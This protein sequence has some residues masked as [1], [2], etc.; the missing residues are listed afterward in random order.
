MKSRERSRNKSN[1]NRAK[2]NKSK[3]RKLKSDK[4]KDK[5]LKDNRTKEDKKAKDNRTKDS[6]SRDNKNKDNRDKSKKSKESKSS[7]K[8]NKKISDQIKSLLM[9]IKKNKKNNSD[10]ILAIVQCFLDLNFI[11]LSKNEIIENLSHSNILS[12]KL[13]NKNFSKNVQSSLKNDIFKK[14]SSSK[15]ELNLEECIHYLKSY[16]NNDKIDHLN[17]NDSNDSKNTSFCP[18]VNLTENENE[19]ENMK[20]TEDDRQNIIIEGNNI[21]NSFTFGEQSQILISNK[22]NSYN[23][24][25]NENEVKNN[26]IDT[27]LEIKVIEEYIP[28]FEFVFDANKNFENLPQKFSQFF[29]IYKNK[30]TNNINKLSEDIKKLNEIIE[31]LN[32]KIKQFNNLSSLFNGEKNELF[33]IKS[34]I[35]QQLNL[36]QFLVDNSFLPKELYND[37]KEILLTYNK[38]FKDLINKLKDHYQNVQNLKPNINEII[39]KLKNFLNEIAVYYELKLD[40]NYSDYYNMI[41][42]INKSKSLEINININE[43]EKLFNSYIKENET[44]LFRIDTQ[45]NQISENEKINLEE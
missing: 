31:D 39:I 7:K 4:S 15:Y 28:E 10:I 9:Q 20:S 45:A 12:S 43:T 41:I 44:I 13:K 21:D 25:N 3:D 37:E 1:D 6:K 5:K 36:M 34:V 29:D 22:I 40:D 2:D 35:H 33:N 16:N 42:N 26:F 18:M 17:S 32:I 38:D 30:N 11:S 19:N 24:E 8:S 23:L 14:K 27:E